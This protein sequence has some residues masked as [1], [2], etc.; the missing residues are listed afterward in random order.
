M[1]NFIKMDD[2]GVPLFWET[3]ILD[4]VSKT[5]GSSKNNTTWNLPMTIYDGVNMKKS[6][7]LVA[8]PRF[9]KSNWHAAKK[10]LYI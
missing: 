4:C 10:T 2:L 9:L 5:L 3:P 7:N 8:A 6:K 1:E